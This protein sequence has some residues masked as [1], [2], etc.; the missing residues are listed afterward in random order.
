MLSKM[1][2]SSVK[3]ARTIDR[4]IILLFVF[5]PV[6]WLRSLNCGQPQKVNQRVLS[7]LWGSH[8]CLTCNFNNWSNFF[9]PYLQSLGKIRIFLELR[10]IIKV[11]QQRQLQSFHDRQSIHRKCRVMY[12]SAVVFSDTLGFLD[13]KCCCCLSFQGKCWT[14]DRFTVFCSVIL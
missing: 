4:T 9:S 3:L 10:R 13:A 8:K 2:F 1:Y 12:K 14:H 11:L 6:L 7:I 5:Y